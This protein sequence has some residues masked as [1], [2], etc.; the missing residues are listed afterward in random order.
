M[1]TAGTVFPGRGSR[2]RTG[3]EYNASL[4]G[5]GSLTL[6]FIDE[7]IASWKAELWTTWGGQPSYSGMAILT[8]LT[9]RAVF[10]L[11]LHQ[12]EG[13]IGSVMGL[14]GLDFAVP[15][16]STLSWRVATVEVPRP[17]DYPGSG[18]LHLL[19][20]SIGLKLCGPASGRTR[21]MP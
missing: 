2:S 11:A 20:D 16:H 9:L 19:V 21:G 1:P 8:A 17:C 14:L 18:P 10:R 12:T 6:W 13:L 3:T 15:D 4:R 7:A 5:H